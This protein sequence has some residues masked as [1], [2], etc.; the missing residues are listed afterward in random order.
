VTVSSEPLLDALRAEGIRA[1]WVLPDGQPTL[2]QG[3]VILRAYKGTRGIE[4][5]PSDM[6]RLLLELVELPTWVATVKELLARSSSAHPW[7]YFAD[8]SRV[9]A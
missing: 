3:Q 2:E 9:W 6:Q 7:P 1:Q 5:R 4:M 8:E